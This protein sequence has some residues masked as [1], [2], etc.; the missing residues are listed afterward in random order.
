MSRMT[1]SAASAAPRFPFGQNRRLRSH[2]EFVHAQRTGRRVVTPHFTLLVAAQPA[3][4][5]A[6]PSRM[7]LVVSGKVGSAV[8]RNRIKRVCRECFRTWPDFL[9]PGVDLVII[10]RPGAHEIS[11]ALVHEEWLAARAALHRRA[12]EALTGPSPAVRPV[13]RTR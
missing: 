12:H 5:G 11:P 4:R 1:S 7:G 6:A 10:A 9:P 8:R 2:V 13:T 3:G